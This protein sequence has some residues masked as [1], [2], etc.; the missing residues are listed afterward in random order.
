MS[1]ISECLLEMYS[2]N[3]NQ[4]YT[5]IIV[6]MRDPKSPCQRTRQDPDTWQ[7]RFSEDRLTVSFWLESDEHSSSSQDLGGARLENGKA[8]KLFG[9]RRVVEAPLRSTLVLKT[10]LRGQPGKQIRDWTGPCTRRK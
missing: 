8:V 7:E 4:P 3:V 5:S 1:H 6:Q 9:R 10:G 2:R